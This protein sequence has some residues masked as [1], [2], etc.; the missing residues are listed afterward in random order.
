MAKTR[1]L[2]SENIAAGVVSGAV[3][4]IIVAVV[5]ALGDFPVG[6]LLLLGGGVALFAGGVLALW[7]QRHTRA[8]VLPPP[9]KPSTPT[10]QVAGPPKPSVSSGEADRQALVRLLSRWRQVVEGDWETQMSPPPEDNLPAKRVRLSVSWKV[11]SARPPRYKRLICEVRDAAWNLYFY[12]LY[13]PT[14]STT[15]MPPR[16]EGSCIF[17]A[18]F[19]GAPAPVDGKHDVRWWALDE[20][21]EGILIAFGQFRFYDGGL[22]L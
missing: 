15:Y 14:V 20:D 9:A 22:R 13:D 12:R 21:D 8:S 16:T 19:P 1:A 4:V 6:Y 10:V 18:D 2:S 7:R 11:S 17:P 5:G 3:G